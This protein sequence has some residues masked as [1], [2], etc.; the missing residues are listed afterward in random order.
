MALEHRST[1]EFYAAKS[2]W[3]AIKFR[4]FVRMFWVL[5]IP[6][7]VLIAANYWNNTFP[8]KYGF[9][10]HAEYNERTYALTPGSSHA[11]LIKDDPSWY[12]THA[13]DDEVKTISAKEWLFYIASWALIGCMLLFLLFAPS[14]ILNALFLKDWRF[15]IFKKTKTVLVQERYFVDKRPNREFVCDRLIGISIG[16]PTDLTWANSGGIAI[17]YLRIM[18]AQIEKNTEFLG[19]YENP[20]AVV[21]EIMQSLPLHEEFKVDIQHKGKS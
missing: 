9:P 20:E 18:G 13:E 8:A 5:V 4:F 15:K 6:L 16:R 3:D 14:D 2:S 7:V 10:S 11:R 17:E 21:K 19:I 1:A 12:A